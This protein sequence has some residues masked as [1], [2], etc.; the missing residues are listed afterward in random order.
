MKEVKYICTVA[1]GIALFVVLTLMIQVPI[2]ENYYICLGYLVMLVYLYKFGTTAGTLVGTVGVVL[3]CILTS[4]LRGMP[5]WVVGNLVIGIC[6]GELLSLTK[7]G[8]NKHKIAF[9]AT[10]TLGIILITILGILICKSVVECL[11][12][13]QPMLIRMGKNVYALVADA[14]VLILGLP[15]LDILDKALKKSDIN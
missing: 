7:K 12:Y 2:F 9:Y 4:G 8:K 1:L 14:V 11:L 5:G 13:S 3:Y 10:N 15:F 6:A